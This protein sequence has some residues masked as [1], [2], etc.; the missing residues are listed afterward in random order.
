[1]TMLTNLGFDVPVTRV[2]TLW[3]D[4]SLSRSVD[5]RVDD[6]SFVINFCNSLDLKRTPGAKYSQ[7]QE[8]H[9]VASIRSAWTNKKVTEASNKPLLL[10]T[11]KAGLSRFLYSSRSA[12]TCKLVHGDSSRG[13]TIA[14]IGQRFYHAPF[15]RLGAYY[16]ATS[17]IFPFRATGVEGRP[18]PEKEYLQPNIKVSTSESCGLA[19]HRGITIPYKSR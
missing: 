10:G 7:L 14:I 2:G 3:Q 15:I 19:S 18:R 11:P 13:G 9:V 8:T 1:M 5:A 12:L 17:D 6:P 16:L 4:R